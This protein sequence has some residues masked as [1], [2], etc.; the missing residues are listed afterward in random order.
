M[1]GAAVNSPEVHSSKKNGLINKRKQENA[2]LEGLGCT[3]SGSY[4]PL[5]QVN[6]GDLLDRTL[7]PVFG[8]IGFGDNVFRAGGDELRN[9]SPGLTLLGVEILF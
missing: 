7:L 5:E 2:N 6:V 8:R 9:A 4:V 3:L 1:N